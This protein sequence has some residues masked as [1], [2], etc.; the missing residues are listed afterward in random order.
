MK[1]LAMELGGNAVFI[2]FES[3]SVSLAVQG[4]M[5]SKFRNT[6]Q[7]CVTA[8][9]IL[10]QRKL[11]D[12]VVEALAAAMDRELKVGPG[13]D[14]TNTQG[15][16]IN[17]R[18]LLK[19]DSFVRDALSKGAKA[20]RGG[21]KHPTGDL[22]YEPTLLVDVTTDMQVFREEIFGPV[23]ALVPFDTEEEALR[24]SNDCDRGLAGYFYTSDLR[25]A[26]RV[27]RSLQVGL[28]GINDPLISTCEAP[29]GGVKMS[30]FGKEGSK[31]GLDEFTNI[32]LLSFGSLD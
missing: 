18:Q 23:A 1:R 2:I 8:N 7:T 25:Q 17:Q 32:K 11:F 16:L 30:G 22:F 10:V 4:L 20:I 14:P 21:R 27:G 15:P 5:A 12:Q 31:H 19:V 26:W 29:F 6:G 28:L 9:R 13:S 3:A 24:V